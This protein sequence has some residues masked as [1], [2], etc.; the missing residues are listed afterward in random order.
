M[1]RSENARLNMIESKMNC[2]QS[3]LTAFSDELGLDRA[4]A[5]K[6]AG[7]FG[8][9][10]GRTGKTCGAVS[11]AYLVIGLS[12]SK[13]AREGVEAVYAK[14]QEFT[15]RFIELHGSTSCTE[16]LKCDLSDSTELA[17]ARVES[18][19]TKACPVFVKGAVEIIEQLGYQ[20]T[21]PV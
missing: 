13:A 19:F 8:G 5:L 11:G 17:R 20:I 18:L 7:G 1:T 3:V 2:A 10:M 16:L 21:S 15:R 12:E 9:G 4:T 14:V 6:L